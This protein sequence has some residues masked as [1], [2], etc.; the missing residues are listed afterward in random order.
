MNLDKKNNSTPQLKEG[1]KVFRETRGNVGENSARGGG[2]SIV[3]MAK[4]KGYGG[5]FNKEKKVTRFSGLGGR[6]TSD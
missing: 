5:I 2:D 6:E 4:L 3:G 1:L